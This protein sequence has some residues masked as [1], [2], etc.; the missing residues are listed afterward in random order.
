MRKF[1]AGVIVGLILGGSATAFA[2]GVF[3]TGYLTGWS[4]MKDGEEVCTDPSVDTVSKEIEC[5]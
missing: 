5:D 3:G 2:A 1:M 4:V